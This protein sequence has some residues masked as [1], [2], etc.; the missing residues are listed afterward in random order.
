MGWLRLQDLSFVA[1][2]KSLRIGR[3]AHHFKYTWVRLGMALLALEFLGSRA[4]CAE[5]KPTTTLTIVLFNYSNASRSILA[6]TK[7]RTDNIFRQ[8]GIGLAWADCPPVYGSLNSQLCRDESAPGEIRVR[9]VDRQLKSYLPD[10]VFGFAIPPVWATVYYESALQLARIATDFDSNVPAIL[11]CLIAHEIGHLLLGQKAHAVD[12][13]MCARWEVWQIQQAMKGE[14]KF[15][16]RQAKVMLR[17]AQERIR[18][19]GPKTNDAEGVGESI[20]D[21]IGTDR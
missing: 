1:R 6:S 16:P 12:G 21:R 17:N 19:P 18:V 5:V 13:V 4:A 2:P 11:S 15:L 3:T 9:I 14:L 10:T 8:S 20:A 7:E